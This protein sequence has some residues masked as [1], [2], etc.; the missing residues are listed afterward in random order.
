M[1]FPETEVKP[2][3]DWVFAIIVLLC[4]VPVVPVPLVALGTLIRSRLRRS[5]T[6]NHTTYKNEAF[7]IEMPSAYRPKD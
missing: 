6:S 3:P 7:E 5:P 4:A 1:N 2:Y